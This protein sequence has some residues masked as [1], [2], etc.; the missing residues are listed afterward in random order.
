MTAD[1]TAKGSKAS[2]SFGRTSIDRRVALKLMGGGLAAPFV[3][4]SAE[5]RAAGP[6]IV[7]NYGGAVA[8][9]KDRVLYKPFTELTGIPI[10]QVAGPDLA[11]IRAQVESGDVEWDVVDVVDPWVYAGEEFGFYEKVPESLYDRSAVIPAARRD[12]SCGSYVY[13]GGMAHSSIRYAEEGQYP[14]SW[15]EFWDVEKIPGRRALLNRVI[16]N[17]ELALMADGVPPEEVY[18]CDVERA[19]RSLDRIKPHI[20][21]WPT[22]AGQPVSLIEADEIDF[23]YNFQQVVVQRR[24]EADAP[25]AFSFNQCLLGILWTAVMKGAPNKD[26]AFRFLEF[27][28]KP[29]QQIAFANITS[30]APVYPAAFSQ[31]DKSLQPWVPDLNRE[32]SL[33]INGG[34]WL[35]KEEELTIRFKEW[36]IS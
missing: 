32:G 17:L 34:W 3:L 30:N 8:E 23:A 16:N 29:E 13:A 1:R 2:A 19:F 15:A 6:L 28:M 21:V 24:R 9:A 20:A 10:V 35:G 4:R 12:Y 22:P 27:A 7:V 14:L 26:A 36:L 25:V 11:K 5:S 18:P 31:I 33:V